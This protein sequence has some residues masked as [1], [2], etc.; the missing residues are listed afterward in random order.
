[1]TEHHAQKIVQRQM[2]KS[3]E[4]WEEMKKKDSGK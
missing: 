3:D 1:M 2:G 4:E